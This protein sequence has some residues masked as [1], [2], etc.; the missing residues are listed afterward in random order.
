MD[1]R[2]GCSRN[3][4]LGPAILSSA[5]SL[6]PAGPAQAQDCRLA[7][8]LALDVS[9]SVDYL[10][11]RFQR[12]GL[13]QALLAPEVVRA[14]VSSEPVALYVFEW[15]GEHSQVMLVPGW[16]MIQSEEDLAR[17]AEAIAAS[18]RS[19][20]DDLHPPT[21]LGAA[22]AHAAEALRKSPACHVRVVDVAGDGQNN[23]GPE[24]WMIYEAGLLDGV[25]VNALIIDQGAD[26]PELVSW[27]ERAVLQG[28]GAFWMLAD[29]YEDYERAMAAKLRRE[30]ELPLVSGRPLDGRAG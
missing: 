11:D 21:A 6:G 30:L 14:F 7:L 2:L 1:G 29:G 12:R 9:E 19:A 24:P 4:A 8:V 3:S 22:L 10:E 13:A 16:Q 25:T 17:I 18:K 23:S 26:D 20:A 27:F 28:P 5:L 15:A